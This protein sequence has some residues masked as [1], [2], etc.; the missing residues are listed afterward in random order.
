GGKIFTLGPD[1]VIVPGKTPEGPGSIE[2]RLYAQQAGEEY[3]I[4]STDFSIPGFRELGLE[5][6]YN[7]IY[8]VST[9]KFEG[10]FIR[11][12]L[13]L[14]EEQKEHYADELRERLQEK[15]LERLEYEKTDIMYVVPNGVSIHTSEPILVSDEETD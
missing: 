15:L 10:G 4:E 11:Q 7:S 3:N 8:A 13:Y 2:V 1:E 9:E 5:D 14:S 12:E 6:R